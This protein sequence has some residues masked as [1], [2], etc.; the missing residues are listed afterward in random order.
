MDHTLLMSTASVRPIVDD[1]DLPIVPRKGVRSCTQHLMINYL[2]YHRL[3]QKHISFLTSLDS[4]IVPNLVTEAL[5]DQ[6]WKQAMSE[7]MSTLKK[8]HTWHLIARPKGVDPIGCRWI[9]NVKYK[10]EGILER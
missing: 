9:F 3:S 1:S 6:N 10:A 2:S 7:E 8:N 4:I 5:R